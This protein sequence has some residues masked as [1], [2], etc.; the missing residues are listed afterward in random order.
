MVTALLVILLVVLSGLTAAQFVLGAF[1]RAASG[2][3]E[4]MKWFLIY[5]AA[6]ILDAAIL[7]SHLR[8]G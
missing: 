1:G 6:S 3:N 4:G 7:A 5:L 8:G 2:S